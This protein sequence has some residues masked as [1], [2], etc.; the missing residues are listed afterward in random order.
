[1]H[2]IIGA[3][4]IRSKTLSQYYALLN[5][6]QQKQ[7]SR[8][9]SIGNKNNESNNSKEAS[10]ELSHL[11]IFLI[12]GLTPYKHSFLNKRGFYT[13]DGTSRMFTMPFDETRTMVSLTI[14]LR[15]QISYT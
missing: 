9:S 3:D 14:V 2:R 1:M 8:K 5:T 15:R 6:I 11:N 13:L 7:K 4:G 10:S 12:L